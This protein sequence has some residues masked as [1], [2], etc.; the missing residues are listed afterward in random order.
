MCRGPPCGPPF[1]RPAIEALTPLHLSDSP[2]PA[3]LTQW[4]FLSLRSS[5]PSL[6]I[7]EAA[8][9]VQLCL[10]HLD[11]RDTTPLPQATG[12]ALLSLIEALLLPPA[13]ATWYVPMPTPA[14]MPLI[15]QP[16]SLAPL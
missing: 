9:L 2:A 3:P 15:T 7:A 6:F 4:N 12:E 11:A 16:F 10:F 14:Y 5:S 8:K 13:G 1:S